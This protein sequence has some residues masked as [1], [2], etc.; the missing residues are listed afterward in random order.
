MSPSVTTSA[1]S[2]LPC[3]LKFSWWIHFRVFRELVRIYEN[4]NLDNLVPAKIQ[5]VYTVHMTYETV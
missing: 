4:K 5:C 2:E 3:L 1:V